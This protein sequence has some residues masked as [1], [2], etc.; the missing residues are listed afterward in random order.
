MVEEKWD[1]NVRGRLVGSRGNFRR[2]EEKSG[3]DESRGKDAREMVSYMI[4]K[5]S[6]SQSVGRQEGMESKGQVEGL[7]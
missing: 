2:M 7:D 4:Q 5:R 3:I 1:G 6:S